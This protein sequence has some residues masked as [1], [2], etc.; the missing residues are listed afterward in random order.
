MIANA[1]SIEVLLHVSFARGIKF[2]SVPISDPSYAHSVK[3]G[4]DICMAA[5]K[6]FTVSVTNLNICQC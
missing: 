3:L 5:L 2:L 1:E 4:E 6:C